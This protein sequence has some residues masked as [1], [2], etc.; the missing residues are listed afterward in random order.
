MLSVLQPATR[1]STVPVVYMPNK[2]AE[3]MGPFLQARFEISV[4]LTPLFQE[5]CLLVCSDEPSDCAP[6]EDSPI[7]LF[8]PGYSMYRLIYSVHAS[9][10]ASEAS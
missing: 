3:H 4:S 7:L 9:S 8:Y 10:I 5:A 1:A 6:K 2:T